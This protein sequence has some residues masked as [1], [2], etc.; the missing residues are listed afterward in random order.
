[1]GGC[2]KAGGRRC[3]VLARSR[4]RVAPSEVAG[5]QATIK[6][7]AKIYPEERDYFK[8][9]IEPLLEESR[10]FVEFAAR[11]VGG[12]RTSFSAG[13]TAAAAR[14]AKRRVKQARSFPRPTSA[15]FR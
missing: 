5:I 1:M 11:S 6:V 13:H 7:A 9:I 2:G 12:P 4:A 14:A 8:S 10:S 15:P 3:E